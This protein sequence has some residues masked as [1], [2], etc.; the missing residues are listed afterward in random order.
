MKVDRAF[1]PR[2]MPIY[3]EESE[4]MVQNFADFSRVRLDS[5]KILCERR[6]NGIV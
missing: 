4:P 6:D 2:L 1:G 3:W 5:I